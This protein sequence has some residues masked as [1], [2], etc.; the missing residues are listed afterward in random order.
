MTGHYEEQFKDDVGHLDSDLHCTDC[1]VGPMW[2]LSCVDE[3]IFLLW[4]ITM[5]F[6]FGMKV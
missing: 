3:R 5:A 6:M 4:D 1:E 2:F